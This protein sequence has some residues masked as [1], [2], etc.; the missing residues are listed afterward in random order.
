MRSG[1]S[2]LIHSQ[3]NRAS[4]CAPAYPN[5]ATPPPRPK[6]ASR[7]YPR[8]GSFP[9]SRAGRSADRGFP[10]FWRARYLL[11]SHAGRS[12]RKKSTALKGFCLA[13][14]AFATLSVSC[15]AQ[16]VRFDKDASLDQRLHLSQSDEGKTQWRS[17]GP[18]CPLSKLRRSFISC[19]LVPATRTGALRPSMERDRS[20]RS[21]SLVRPRSA[22]DLAS[23]LLTTVASDDRPS[24]ELSTSA[25]LG[26]ER[27]LAARLF[28]TLA[29]STSSSDSASDSPRPPSSPPPF[30]FPT[31]RHDRRR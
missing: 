29:G 12:S 19:S 3:N 27:I 30:G 23:A 24:R 18:L 14:G 6:R 20:S 16:G 17:L 11:R 8:G 21:S 25:S 31:S 10:G 15:L 7:T 22:G 1:G 4:S 5:Y 9:A 13:V 2:S 26:W 28:A